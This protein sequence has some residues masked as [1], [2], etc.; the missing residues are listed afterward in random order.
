MNNI[1]TS[2]Q[3]RLISLNIDL[4]KKRLADSDYKVIKCAECSLLETPLPYDIETL[5]AARQA[6]RNR[7]NTLE[8]EL[9]L[10]EAGTT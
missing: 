7:I 10:L 8:A 6:T 5:H 1:F 3:K 4:L 9:S 2:T